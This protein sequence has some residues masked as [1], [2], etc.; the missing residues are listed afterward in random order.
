MAARLSSPAAERQAQP[1]RPRRRLGPERSSGDRSPPGRRSERGGGLNDP[2]FKFERGQTNERSTAASTRR[3]SKIFK[4]GLT[5][6]EANR[7]VAAE[8]GFDV[9]ADKTTPPNQPAPARSTSR[10]RR[11]PRRGDRQQVSR[12]DALH[13]LINNRHGRAL[14]QTHKSNKKEPPMPD[15]FCKPSSKTTAS[16]PSAKASSTAAAA[17]A[18]RARIHQG[19]RDYA[20]AKR[21]PGEVSAKAFAASFLP[22]TMSAWCCARRIRSQEHDADADHAGLRRRHRGN[23]RQ[24]S[25]D[26]LEQL[27]ALAERLRASMPA[28][29]KAQAFGKVYSDPANAALAP[30]ERRQNRPTPDV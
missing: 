22:T 10:S 6:N 11:P 12:E 27:Q 9:D 30:R 13:C 24:R 14:A 5:A 26:A 16:S 8:N 20:D 29:S 2:I 15:T 25:E 1:R 21:L 28:L 17:T 4:D 3:L 7:A 19:G 23:R 18:D